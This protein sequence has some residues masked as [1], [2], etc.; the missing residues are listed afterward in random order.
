MASA[1]TPFPPSA[2]IM[3]ADFTHS[4]NLFTNMMWFVCFRFP[5]PCLRHMRN[6]IAGMV[7]S[8]LRKNMWTHFKFSHK[9]NK[10]NPFEKLQDKVLTEKFIER[11]I[12]SVI[13]FWAK[14][15]KNLI[16]IRI[17]FIFMHGLSQH[18]KIWRFSSYLCLDR[19]DCS[20]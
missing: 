15:L 16:N 1:Q 8:H 7:L 4:M 11:K 6:I 19:N 10:F 18:Q 17:N 2:R 5:F 12:G 20:S 9:T 13:G 14:L 3:A